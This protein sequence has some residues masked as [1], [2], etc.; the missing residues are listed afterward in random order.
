MR[1]QAGAVPGELVSTG[2]V[3]GKM[4]RE[5]RGGHVKNVIGAR[6]VRSQTMQ[7]N[8]SA[9]GQRARRGR[10]GDLGGGSRMCLTAGARVGVM[11]DP[12]GPRGN[13]QGFFFRAG[14]P[15]TRRC[16]LMSQLLFF[17]L[18]FFHSDEHTI[19]NQH[20]GMELHTLQLGPSPRRLQIYPFQ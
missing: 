2:G 7:K 3:Q 1:H 20:V 19:E 8:E 10:K 12:A 18:F 9:T 16:A 4:A 5:E 17:F 14:S 11:G 15:G 6:G 13:R